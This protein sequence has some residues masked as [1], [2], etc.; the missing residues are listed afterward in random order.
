MGFFITTEF[1]GVFKSGVS[2]RK[3]KKGKFNV[4]L[5]INFNVISV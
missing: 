2:R 1:H 4:G 5:L 3:K